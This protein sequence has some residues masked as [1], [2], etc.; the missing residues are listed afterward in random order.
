M[1][2]MRGTLQRYLAAVV[3]GLVLAVVLLWTQLDPAVPAS[4]AV[5][6]PVAGALD[7]ALEPDMEAMLPITFT[8]DVLYDPAAA[9]VRAQSGV[10]VT[11]YGNNN[12]PGG[13]VELDQTVSARDGSFQL[14]AFSDP[15]WESFEI[16]SGTPRGFTPGV[17]RSTSGEATIR[18][19]NSVEFTGTVVGVVSDTEFVLLDPVLFYPRYHDRYLVVTSEAV[20]PALDEFLDYKRS[21]GFDMIVRT[22]EELDPGGIGGNYL[23]GQIRSLEQ[24][25]WSEPGSLTYVL[26]IGTH[27]TVPY[28]LVNPHKPDKSRAP[29]EEWPKLTCSPEDDQPNNCGKGSDWYYVDLVSDWD[30][31]NDDILAELFWANPDKL[32]EWE[33][34]GLLPSGYQ[35]DDA[36]GFQPTVFLGRLQMDSPAPV[37][38]ALQTM[39]AFEQDGGEW[40]LNTLLAGAMSSVGGLKW[41]VDEEKYTSQIAPTDKA[42]MM[43]YIYS[44]FL[45][46]RG[47]SA[48]RLYEQESPYGILPP[49]T[50][51]FPVDDPLTRSNFNSRWSSLPYGLVQASGHGSSE[52]IS[53]TYWENDDNDTHIPESP[54]EPAGSTVTEWE[55]TK[56]AF[57]I[58]DNVVYRS[59]P[60]GKTPILVT[61][62]CSNGYWA[63]PGN[64][65]T[66]LLTEGKVAAWIGGVDTIYYK[67]GWNSPNFP[68]GGGQMIDYLISEALFDDSL[69][70]GD[71]VWTGLAN[72]YTWGNGSQWGH[73]SVNGGI[74]SF[75]LYGDPSANY[76]GNS[77]S[78]GSPWPMFH[79][80]WAGRGESALL[81][82]YAD[83]L[84]AASIEWTSPI[85]TAAGRDMPSP[86]VGDDGMIYVGDSYGTVHAIAGNGTELWTYPTDDDIVGAP[87]VSRD[88]TIYVK[89]EDGTLQALDPYGSRVWADA[90]GDSPASPKIGIDGTIYVG[91]SDENG[92]GGSKRY[93]VAGYRPD[94]ARLGIGV[95]DD[96]VTTTPTIASDG[97]QLFVGTAAGTVYS[98]TLGV[99]SEAWSVSPGY[100]IGSGIALDEQHKLLLVPS[101]SGELICVGLPSGGTIWTQATGGPIRSAPALGANRQAIFGSQ[102]GKV[103][104][105]EYSVLLWEYDTGG[106]VDSSPALDPLTA[107][108]VG[109]SPSQVY[110]IDRASGQLRWSIPLGGDSAGGSS[111]A[112]G[113]GRMLYVAAG[114]AGPGGP[115]DSA[116]VA[117]GPE[118]WSLPPIPNLTTREPGMIGIEFLVGDPFDSIVVERRM[119]G[120]DWGMITTLAPGVTQ[121]NDTGVAAGQVYQYRG[122]AIPTTGMQGPAGGAAAVATEPSDYSQ[123]VTVQG[124]PELPE[125][126][127]APDV[128]AL[129]ATELRLTWDM[130]ISNVI[131]TEIL[132]QGPGEAVSQTVAAVPGGVLAYDDTELEPA[133][134]YAYWLRAVNASGPSPAS[135]VGYGTTL[136][137]T[138]PAPENVAVTPLANE[139]FMVCWEPGATDLHSVIARLDEG[140]AEPGYVATV[141]PGQNCYTDTFAYFHAFEYWVKHTNSP[142]TDESE[143][144]RSASVAPPGYDWGYEHIYL[145]VM[146]REH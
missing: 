14:T 71:A 83:D 88:G 32:Q 90:V 99:A 94:G 130:P 4:L 42:W 135:P 49:R 41:D 101:T 12:R 6:L 68:G 121:F 100:A 105:M 104:A 64:L 54:V 124:L 103:Y 38:Q 73:R 133:S 81:G 43:E 92:P 28:L 61:M 111:P 145:P 125:A 115:V 24:T 122:M 70:L 30:S 1:Q 134:E 102:D 22:V 112:I 114:P 26:L 47:F 127:P 116:L 19:P 10:S 53:R 5:P 78:L 74:H 40:K 89:V 93:F 120:G 79:Y 91:G 63:E 136:L 72:Y 138:L 117:I 126:P 69:P 76:W 98:L 95:V 119:P 106:P 37:Q 52:G 110:A 2:T 129:S 113:H 13:P 35:P 139:T 128:T 33:D 82:P 123:A 18:A 23:R 143:W 142:P 86:V 141:S 17:A 48:V 80:D 7:S 21:L 131:S 34:E 27:D 51:A 144:A 96:M 60:G 20:V 36:P 58:R 62:S 107:Y 65:P 75:D 29:G 9:T 46:P 45:Q 8:G 57:M 84:P 15:M 3:A 77:A 55:V 11:L 56:T 97:H 67:P 118:T 137:Q 59:M 66:T 39:M 140:E 146:L 132:R 25:L 44:D 85:A 16:R 108:V 50:S 31:N 87:A 109:G